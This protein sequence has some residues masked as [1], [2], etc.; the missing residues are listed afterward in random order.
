MAVD[1][2]DESPPP[3]KL[4]KGKGRAVPEDDD[5]LP[6]KRNKGKGRAVPDDDDDEQ[7]D[8]DDEAPPQ[9][10]DKGKG[11]A[12]EEEEEE[13]HDDE[14]DATP[15]Q[16]VDKGKG[17]GRAD[18]DDDEEHDDLTSALVGTSF[19]PEFLSRK[20]YTQAQ[21]DELRILYDHIQGTCK[22]L[23]RSPQAVLKACGLS[24]AF[25]RG[26]NSFNI[27]E[28]WL[29]WQADTPSNSELDAFPL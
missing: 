17:K 12:P 19:S 9:K 10:V 18:L 6:P 21:I 7:E 13:E 27:F 23:K 5:A 3:R 11:R 16:K 24:I 2:E 26:S 1:D 28:A 8:E 15:P 29:K 4:R 14:D 25:A 20:G 22:S